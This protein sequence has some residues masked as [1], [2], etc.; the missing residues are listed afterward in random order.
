MV[1]QLIAVSISAIIS[2]ILYRAGGMGK[3]KDA[4]PKWI[5]MWLRFDKARDALCPLVLLGLVVFLFGFRLASWW[6]YL[7]FFGLSWGALSSYWDE[8][9]KEDNFYAHGLGI[10]LAGIPLIWCGVAWW[11]ILARL[12]LCTVGMGLWSKFIKNDVAEEFGRGVLF[13]I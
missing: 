4:K 12:T 6:A 10:G 9:F 2:G 3:D 11:I 1:I 13:I 8:I 5:P 7:L